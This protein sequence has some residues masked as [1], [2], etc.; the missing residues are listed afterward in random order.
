MYNLAVGNAHGPPPEGSLRSRPSA[1]EGSWPQGGSKAPRE[2][3]TLRVGPR[4]RSRATFQGWGRPEGPVPV[5]RCPTR[6]S[7]ALSGPGRCETVTWAY[8]DADFGHES[9]RLANVNIVLVF[10]Y[11]VVGPTPSLR[12]GQALGPALAGASPGPTLGMLVSCNRSSF[13]KP[14]TSQGFGS[15]AAKRRNTLA[16]GASPGFA[17]PHPAFGTPLP[18]GRERGRGRGRVPQPTALRRGLRYVAPSE[19][20]FAGNF[21]YRTLVASRL[22]LYSRRRRWGLSLYTRLPGFLLGADG[23]GSRFHIRRLA[24]ASGLTQ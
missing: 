14:Q 3:P 22:I 24:W 9:T 15:R 11:V 17:G 6:R 16:Q 20:T 12:S 5:G 13:I 19:L 4:R 2:K 7:A 8:Y 21:G 18:R 23:L 10:V 1:T